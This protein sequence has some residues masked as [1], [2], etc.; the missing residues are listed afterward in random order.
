MSKVYEQ[1]KSI[2]LEEINKELSKKSVEKLISKR[3]NQ[4]KWWFLHDPKRLAKFYISRMIEWYDPRDYWNFDHS[5]KEKMIH[6]LK[7]FNDIWVMTPYIAYL[8]F[9]NFDELY[10]LYSL[11]DNALSSHIEKNSVKIGFSTD[12]FYDRLSLNTKR[13]YDLLIQRL[14]THLHNDENFINDS[15]EFDKTWFVFWKILPTLNY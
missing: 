2:L 3:E 10:E 4:K 13:I 8:D 15:D 7:K 1:F 14:E 12:E 6:V 5:M 9:N 11:S